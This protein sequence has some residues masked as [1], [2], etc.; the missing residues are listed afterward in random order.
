MQSH[1]QFPSDNTSSQ[2]KNEQTVGCTGEMY[3]DNIKKGTG[4]HAH[5]SILFIIILDNY[6]T[7]QLNDNVIIILR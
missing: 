1:L 6:L 5:T 4:I 7:I 2:R 3:V